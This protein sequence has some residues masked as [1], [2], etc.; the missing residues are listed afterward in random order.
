M[1][2]HE[3]SGMF[4]FAVPL[5]GIET[6]VGVYSVVLTICTTEPGEYTVS[7]EATVIRL[8]VGLAA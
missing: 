6:D 7:P 5:F 8:V 2:A 1:I 3:K 4:V